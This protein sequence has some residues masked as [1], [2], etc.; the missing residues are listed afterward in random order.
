MTLSPKMWLTK[1]HLR[2]ANSLSELP[3]TCM[4]DIRFS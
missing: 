2:F 1:D 3:G 4:D